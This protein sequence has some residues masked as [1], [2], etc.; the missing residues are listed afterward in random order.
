[1]A[2]NEG[3]KNVKFLNQIN[4]YLENFDHEFDESNANCNFNVTYTVVNNKTE[5]VR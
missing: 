4:D 1:M 2:A 3:T 5:K